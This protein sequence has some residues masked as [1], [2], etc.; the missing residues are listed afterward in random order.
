M[1]NRPLRVV[2]CGTGTIGEHGLRAVIGHPDL[3]LVGLL[4]HT[5]EK[6]GRD[7]G[8]LVGLA[9]AGVQASGDIDVLLALDADALSYFAPTMGRE[10]EAVQ[11]ISAFLERGANVSTVA[12]SGLVDPSSADPAVAATL[13]RAAE[14]GQA[15]FFTTGIEPGFVTTQFPTTML[16]ICSDIESV[17][18]TEYFNYGK[19]PDSRFIC[20]IMGFGKPADYVGAMF[21]PGG[22]VSYDTLWGAAVVWLTRQLGA[23]VERLQLQRDVW[24]TDEDFEMAAGTIHAGTVGAIRFQIQAIVNGEP[25]VVAEHVNFGHESAAPQ[26]DR[27]Q[28]GDNGVYRVI[29]RGKPDLD[30]QMVFDGRHAGA[31]GGRLACANHIVNAIPAVCAA[32]PGILSVVDLTP[33]TGR[34]AA[35][36]HS[37]QPTTAPR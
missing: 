31:L 6:L 5:P 21:V 37:S 4:A 3:E 23:Q 34:F 13:E 28:L 10:D 32:R 27:P 29:V 7:A 14:R 18:T 20:D 30:V 9:P 19:Y 15:S 36:N 17:L 35:L 12:L 24:I 33:F 11:Q 1:T 8:E 16:S 26:W 2:H 25:L 22:P